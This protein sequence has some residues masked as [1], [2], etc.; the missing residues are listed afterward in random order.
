MKTKHKKFNRT[1]TIVLLI[2]AILGLYVVTTK[3]SPLGMRLS[4]QQLSVDTLKAKLNALKVQYQN[5][6]NISERAQLLMQIRALETQIKNT[7]T[8]QS[9]RYVVR[10]MS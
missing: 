10:P 7:E 5:T 3:S 9:S 6:Q 8:M 2:I 4:N 1:K